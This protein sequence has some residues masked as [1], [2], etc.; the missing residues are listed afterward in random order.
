MESSTR[1]VPPRL[2]GAH[3]RSIIECLLA[4]RLERPE[5]MSRRHRIP[6]FAPALLLGSCVGHATSATAQVDPIAA[7]GLAYLRTKGSSAGGVGE[8]ALAALAMIK[9][10][11]PA[12]DPAL[13]G[14]INALRSRFGSSSYTPEKG[15]GGEIYEAGV[16]IIALSN[17][18][19]EAHR[20]EIQAAAD[21]LIGKQNANGSWD[22]QGRTAGDTSISQYAVL[23]LWEAENAGIRVDPAIWD[24]AAAWYL[25]TQGS[26]GGW[27][28]HPDGGRDDTVS[29]TAAG[30]GSLLI[31]LRQLA[32]YR[33]VEKSVNPLLIP[34]VPESERRRFVATTSIASINGGIRSGIAWLAGTLNAGVGQNVGPSPFYALYGIERVGALA[35]Q[36]TLGRVDWFNEGRRYL[37]STQQANGS[38]N[39]R[40]GDV[41]ETAWAVLFLTKSTAKTIKRI[42]VRRLG[43][44]TLVGGRGLPKD[45]SQVSVAGGK[46]IA[47]PMD[48]AV[49]GMIAALEDPRVDDA[50]S[51]L[52]GLIAR[53]GAEGSQA[54]APHEERFR[55]LLADP[56]QGVRRVAAWALARCGDPAAAPVLIKALG[57]P[58]EGVVREARLGL[59]L[60][61][62]LIEGYGPPDGAPPEERER[63]AARWTAWYESI[64]PVGEARPAPAAGRRTP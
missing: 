19:A 30:V 51:A 33:A 47:R 41:P 37:A 18:D 31:C 38:F 6:W 35:D 10:D 4:P 23:G 34:L 45:L 25:S 26:G 56:D 16:V 62:R 22:Y 53:Y 17:H 29:M 12:G 7:R 52:A 3:P 64:R 54:L 20:A 63:A 9:G 27:T 59:Q 58:D 1:S 14:A 60:M 8:S 28:Y 40:F 57:D 49:E 11:V 44:G 32:P 13:V 48:G 39:V 2:L 15:S 24:R 61:A 21:F 5:R 55:K 43:S 36:A 46:V 42:Q 50:S